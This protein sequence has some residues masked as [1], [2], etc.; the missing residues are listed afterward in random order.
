MAEANTQVSVVHMA[1]DMRACPW[2]TSPGREADRV[3]QQT[4]RGAS[5]I[6]RPPSPT[7]RMSD[8]HHDM[9]CARTPH[10]QQF[11][12]REDDVRRLCQIWPEF[13]IAT[14]AQALLERS[15]LRHEVDMH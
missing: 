9:L 6:P 15:A 10:V 1:G 14:C 5:R 8:T 11:L 13:T 4:S 3:R 7:A 12:D 2:P